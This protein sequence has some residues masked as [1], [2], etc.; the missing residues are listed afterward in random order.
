MGKN[1][2]QIEGWKYYNHA[3]IPTTAPHEKV[4]EEPLKNGEIWKIVGGKPLFARYSTDWD[5]KEETDWWYVIK[6]SPFDISELKSKR[7]YEINKGI[8]NFEVRK[9]NQI[10]Y[11]NDICKIAFNV[12]KQYPSKYRPNI[13]E[14]NFINDIKKWNDVIVYGAFEIET[15]KMC[16]YAILKENKNYLNFIQLKAMIEFEKKGL[17]FAIINQILNDYNFKL[18]KNFYICDGTRNVIHE[19]K[20]QDFLEKYFGFRKAYC[21]LV[22]KYKFPI[23]LLVEMLKPFGKTLSLFGDWGEKVNA[24]LFMDNIAKECNRSKK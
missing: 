7:R 19:T 13:T 24:I 3:V 2:K 17:N 8:K 14:E 1:R 4:N 20:F 12:W 9:I 15:N 10:M 18:S 22:I 23:K 16:G 5:C 11:A 21:K 6:D